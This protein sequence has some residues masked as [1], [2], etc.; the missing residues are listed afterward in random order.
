[1][2]SRPAAPRRAAAS[3]P[4]DRLKS[5]AAEG[6]ARLQPVVRASADEPRPQQ[7]ELSIRDPG[8]EE[9]LLRAARLS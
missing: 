5:V 6:R 9:V 3:S 7:P 2:P 1:M 8:G 4:D